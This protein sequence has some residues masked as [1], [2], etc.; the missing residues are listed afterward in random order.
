M[1]THSGH[2]HAY[3]GFATGSRGLHTNLVALEI[4][5]A[6]ATRSIAEEIRNA[7]SGECAIA[8]VDTSHDMGISA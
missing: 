4:F 8:E 2:R 3:K 5:F 1:Y 6:Y 7:R